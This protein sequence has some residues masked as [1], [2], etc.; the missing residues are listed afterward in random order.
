MVKKALL[1]F[2]RKEKLQREREALLAQHQSHVARG[3]AEAETS[4][5]SKM[6]LKKQP[7]IRETAK[8][9]QNLSQ[10][11]LRNARTIK[12]REY[13]RAKKEREKL[14]KLVE[15]EAKKCNRKQEDK[16]DNINQSQIDLSNRQKEKNKNHQDRK[17]TEV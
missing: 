14:S 15:V 10:E 4:R 16:M 5:A 9:K 12:N 3:K 1:L 2:C 7:E 11:E 6:K 17:T 8:S 13:R